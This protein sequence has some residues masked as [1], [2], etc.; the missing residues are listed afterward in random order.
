MNNE[1]MLKYKNEIGGINMSYI[2]PDNLTV[3]TKM[4]YKIIELT[5]YFKEIM[6]KQYEIKLKIK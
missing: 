4:E 1:L 2:D 6:I 5:E 3:D